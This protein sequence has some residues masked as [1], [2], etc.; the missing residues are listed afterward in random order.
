MKVILAFAALDAHIGT[1]AVGKHAQL[2]EISSE[3]M[4]ESKV[5]SEGRKPLVL[6]ER[7]EHIAILAEKLAD[8]GVPVFLLH[9]G[10]SAKERR[11]ELA[12]LAA[13]PAGSPRLLIAT[14]RYI[15]EGV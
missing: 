11:I 3:A 1:N 10:L 5:L 14:G 7:K 4:A 15:G 8:C 9:G 2:T 12:R 13:L 6:T